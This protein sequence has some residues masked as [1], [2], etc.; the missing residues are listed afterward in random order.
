MKLTTIPIPPDLLQESGLLVP[1]DT[2]LGLP[3]IAAP[4]RSLRL[5]MAAAMIG[6]GMN[7]REALLAAADLYYW[8]S[9]DLDKPGQLSQADIER[10]VWGL[11]DIHNA[12]QKK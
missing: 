8:S 4:N 11:V 9:I 12:H 5:L 1:P 10:E 2:D 6:D 3:A 7:E